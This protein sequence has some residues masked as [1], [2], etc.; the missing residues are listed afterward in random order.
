M[1]AGWFNHMVEDEMEIVSEIA[2]QFRSQKTSLGFTPG[3]RPSG[4]LRH[5][6]P[7][8]RRKL[9]GLTMR[10]SRM[11]Q[12]GEIKVLDEGAPAPPQTLSDVANDRCVIFTEV[13]DLDL[14]KE[15]EKIKKKIE[16]SEKTMKGLE[17]KMN[18]A[19]YA[20]KVPE[21]IREKNAQ[22][23]EATK[24]ELAE[25]RRAVSQIEAATK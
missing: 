23:L 3:A 18:V 12:I 2:K 17:A 19:G 11:A 10:L 20:E 8:V 4:Y 24:V 13:K 22:N 1:V 16:S 21:A 25:F 14:T 9:A 6:D 7:E 5:S 15:L